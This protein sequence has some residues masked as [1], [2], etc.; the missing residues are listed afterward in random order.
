MA[1]TSFP[2]SRAIFAVI[3]APLFSPASTTKTP[4]DNPLIILFL[5]G[6]CS[7]NGFVPLGYSE[8]IHPPVFKIHFASSLFCVGY[9]LSIPHPKTAIVLP[10]FISFLL[11]DFLYL[12]SF[13]FTYFVDI[14]L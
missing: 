13:S 1:K 11:I 8:I 5:S 4:S 3:I 6:K 7:F 12:V 10:V 2:C 9:N 14:W